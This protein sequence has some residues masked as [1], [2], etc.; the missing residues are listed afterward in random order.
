MS[1]KLSREYSHLQFCKQWDL[2]RE[3][4]FM[5]GQCDMLIKVLNNISIKPQYYSELQ[6]IMLIKGAQATTA[7][8]G[9]TLTD[10]EIAKIERGERLPP[11]KGYQETEVK[12]ILDA[13]NLL[14]EETAV[15]KKNI[16]ISQDLLKRFH[17][18]VGKNL[19]AH[20]A[21]I[22]GKFRSGSENVTVGRYRAAE[23]VDVELLIDKFCAF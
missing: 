18:M 9:N 23:G 13:I 10:E 14:L 4:Y 22:P 21:A 19:G 2:S 16:L 7:I 1:E 17:Y 5:L 3:D 6:E 8:E 20:F 11:S 12:N 15:D